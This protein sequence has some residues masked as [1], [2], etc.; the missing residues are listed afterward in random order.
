MNSVIDYLYPVAFNN[1]R[2]KIFLFSIGSYPHRE[3][4]NH[5]NP[6]IYKSLKNSQILNEDPYNNFELY[7]VL[8]DFEYSYD[9]V[10]PDNVQKN[11][12][13]NTVIFKLQIS[14]RDY[15]TLIDFA[16][17]IS[18]VN[19]LSIIM[20]F[21]SVQRQY[22]NNLSNFVYVT[23]NDCLGDTNNILYQPIIYFDKEINKYIFYN[24]EN[25]DILFDEYYKV[26]Q[27]KEFNFNK[28]IYIRELIKQNFK[29]IDNIYRKILNFIK[30]E[31]DNTDTHICF[32]KNSDFYYISKN[33]LLHRL[34]GYTYKPA[35]SII[36]DFEKSDINNLEVYL[37]NIIKNI[38]YDCCYIEN[39][40][41]CNNSIG[42]LSII[43]DTDKELY[44]YIKHFRKYFNIE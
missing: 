43:I 20:E 10:M 28:L 6:A 17:I 18:K 23:P 41:K 3:E 36:V 38:L 39:L 12:D 7:R 42:K 21:T 32:D 13:N 16:N 31:E 22:I 24:L 30:V 40:D 11:F 15:Y 19:C 2:P 35:Q 33:K 8:I 9:E 26:A 25:R 37:K 27:E 44:L 1:N 5:E 29:L 34:A 4:S 14:E